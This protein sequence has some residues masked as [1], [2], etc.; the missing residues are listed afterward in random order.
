MKYVLLCT[1]FFLLCGFS[2]PRPILEVKPLVKLTQK[3]IEDYI[4]KFFPS[5]LPNRTLEDGLKEMQ[6]FFHMTVTGKIDPSIT[7]IMTK[8][9]CGLPDVAEFRRS[10]VWNKKDL[11]YRIKNYTPDLPKSKVDEI[12]KKA[13]EVWSAVTPLTFR[14]VSRLADIEILF[15][16]GAHGDGNSFDGRGGIL[17]HAFFPG[18]GIGGDAHFDESEQWS[19]SNKEINFFLVAAHEFGH[20][21]GLEHTNVR[22]ALMYPTYSYVNPT[23]FRL[24]D[25]DRQRIQRLYGPKE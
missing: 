20:S 23:T 18:R 10:S 9:R 2:F 6:N 13:W 19:E 16:S 22:G 24:H 21:L 1:A 7:E 14:K 8:S 5:N 4:N 12:I 15:A 17:A 25:D 11:T 3:F